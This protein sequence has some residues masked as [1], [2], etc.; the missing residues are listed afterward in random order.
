MQYPSNLEDFEQ[1]LIAPTRAIRCLLHKVMDVDQRCH[2]KG[3]QSE[4][5]ASS[6]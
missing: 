6:S 5:S 4:V 1:Q 3:A 2:K